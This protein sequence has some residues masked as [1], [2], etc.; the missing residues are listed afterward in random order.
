MGGLA[1]ILGAFAAHG[2][3][4]VLSDR[5]LTAFETGAQY[6]MYHA[7]AIGLAALA[8]RDRAAR[9]ANAAAALFLIGIALFSGSLYLMAFTGLTFLGMVTPLGG[10]SMMAGWA[11]LALAALKLDK[12]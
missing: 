11:V 8:V 5:M 3:R 2:L 7:L 1:V 6:Q 9:L 10:L 4:A 12:A